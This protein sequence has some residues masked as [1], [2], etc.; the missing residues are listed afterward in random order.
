MT[1]A[2]DTPVCSNPA[3]GAERRRIPLWAVLAVPLGLAAQEAQPFMSLARSFSMELPE[4]WRQVTPAELV[5]LRQILP[6]DIHVTRPRDFYT[7]GPVDRWLDGDFD[8]VHLVVQE[9]TNELSM[10][11]DGIGRILSHWRE[12]SGQ[13]GLVHEI[14]STE[15]TEVGT[16]DHPA[17]LCER[18]IKPEGPGP[19]IQSLD[20]Y[21]PSGG[22]QILLSFRCHAEDFEDQLP[23]FRKMLAS[24]SF[25]RTARGAETLGSKL[26]MPAIVGAFVGLML[27]VL[28]RRRVA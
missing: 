8:G 6:A 28:H 5:D 13:G 10:D 7:L 16:D 4:S 23:G 21:I 19:A 2:T 17:I 1:A 14:L 24:A 20:A 26:V 3:M 15:V 25:A 22:R 9:Q 18:L 27:L 11:D 12:V